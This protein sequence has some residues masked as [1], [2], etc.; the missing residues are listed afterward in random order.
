MHHRPLDPSVCPLPK[1]R[2]ILLARCP[3]CRRVTPQERVIRLIECEYGG[4]VVITHTIEDLAFHCWVCGRLRGGGF[5]V[6]PRTN[7]QWKQVGVRF[8]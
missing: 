5:P 3:R 7:D 6:R 4:G 1:K 2:Q 8:S